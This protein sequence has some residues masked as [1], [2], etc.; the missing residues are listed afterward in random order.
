LTSPGLNNDQLLTV[1]LPSESVDPLPA[2]LPILEQ[3]RHWV[4]ASGL[5]HIAVIM[6][7]NRRWAKAR[8][9][10]VLAGHQQGVASLKRFARLAN[11]SGVKVITAY[12]FSTENWNRSQQEVGLLMGLFVSALT[13]EL[14]DLHAEGVRL[15]FIG[16]LEAMPPAVQQTFQ[17]AV[18][19]TQH[20]TGVNLRLAVNYGARQELVDAV[21]ILAHQVQ[22]GT[23]APQAI[24]AELISAHLYQVETCGDPD[25]LIRPGGEHRLSNFL[26]WQS[27]Y[28]ELVWSNALW[29][30]YDEACLLEAMATYAQRQRRFGS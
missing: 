1:A 27:A 30:D 19:L 13:H 29:P 14:G 23:L 25:V 3:A 2:T 18:A 12:A 4:Q 28:T 15:S 11:R 16:Q 9:L 21:Q 26:L 6:D 8:G 10:P 20:N 5:R 24:T 7:G 17:K 22:A